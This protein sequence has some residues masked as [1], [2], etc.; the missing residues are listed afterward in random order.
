[1]IK[2]FRK[3]RQSLLTEGKFRQYLK[4]AVGEIVLVVIGI[5]IALSIND[6][7]DGRKL[8]EQRQQ[9]ISSLLEDFKYNRDLLRDERLPTIVEALDNMELFG[10][11][12]ES[13]TAVVPVDSL[14][15][16]GVAFFR[17]F[18][19]TA[20]LTSLNEATS[21]GKL[22]LL[23]NKELSK[24]FTRFQLHF[25]MY[26]DLDDESRYCYFNGSSW[27]VRK[28]VPPDFL[29]G[30]DAYPGLSYEEY[31]EVIDRPLTQAA[32]YNAEVLVRN[33]KNRLSDLLETSEQI[34]SILDKMQKQ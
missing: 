18:F 15:K 21:S 16:L 4:Y 13:D 6:W 32:L 7:N 19:F 29:A 10:N 23:N 25:E 14:R 24:S 30:G 34:I 12:T 17:G 3:I 9:L 11:L 33:K 20:N 26:L 1:M 8:K 28:T 2:F 22:S 31:K 5:L 27:E